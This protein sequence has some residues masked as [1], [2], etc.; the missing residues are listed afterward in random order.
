MSGITF[1]YKIIKNLLHT[2]TEAPVPL[3]VFKNLPQNRVFPRLTSGPVF[4]TRSIVTPFGIYGNCKKELKY[5]HAKKTNYFT[6]LC[7][8]SYPGN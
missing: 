4:L 8:P 2:D 6:L 7:K 3:A 5:F 1:H